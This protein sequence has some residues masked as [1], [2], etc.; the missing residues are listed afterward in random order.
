MLRSLRLKMGMLRL[1]ATEE[2]LCDFGRPNYGML[3]LCAAQIRYVAIIVTQNGYVATLC[4]RNICAALRDPNRYVATSRVEFCDLFFDRLDQKW[5]GST[6]STQ[7]R[8]VSTDS[9]QAVYI[10][11][12][13]DKEKCFDRVRPKSFFDRE[14]FR[15]RKK[16]STVFDREKT[17]RRRSTEEFFRPKKKFST[18]LMQGFFD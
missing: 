16:L 4:D 10:S 9:T 8:Y 14:E 5:Y 13:F 1:C 2:V 18:T 6:V 12:K 11:T 7:A 17:F 15:P 3:L